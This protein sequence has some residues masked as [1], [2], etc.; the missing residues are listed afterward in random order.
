MYYENACW[1][2]KPSACGQR[3]VLR[4]V[5]RFFSKKRFVEGHVV[6]NIGTNTIGFGR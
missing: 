6:E 1:V 2:L 3:I 5:L 4:I